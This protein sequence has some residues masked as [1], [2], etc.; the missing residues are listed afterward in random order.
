MIVIKY[1]LNMVN[2]RILYINILEFSIFFQ[3]KF[4]TKK[5]Y[6]ITI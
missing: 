1:T 5:G 6:K 3:P 2:H 4:S